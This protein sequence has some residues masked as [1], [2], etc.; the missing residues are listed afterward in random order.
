MP[1][2]TNLD[3]LSTTPSSNSPAGSESAALVDEYLRQTAA[4]LATLRNRIAGITEGTGVV[5]PMG[6]AGA[7]GPQGAQGIQGVAGPQGPAGTSVALKG[8]IATI[9]ALPAIGNT[10]GDLYVVLADGNG[11]VWSGSGWSNAGPIRGPAGATGPA[12]PQGPTGATGPQGATGPA[13]DPTLSAALAVSTDP[14]KGPGLINYSRSTTYAAGTVGEK[15]TR[16]WSPMDAPYNAKGDGTTDDTAALASFFTTLPNNAV[17]DLEGRSYAVYGSVSGIAA[18]TDALA[19]GSCLRLSSKSNITIRNGRIFAASPGTSGSLVNF[20][21]TLSIDGCTNIRLQ[22]VQLEAKGESYGNSDSSS[23]LSTTARRAYLA[24]N[25]G[26]A[27]VVI[28]SSG[29]HADDNCRFIRAGST[30]S[31]YASSSDNVWLVGAYSSPMS[32]GYAAFCADSWCGAIATSGFPAHRMHLIGCR[33]DSNGAT[34]GS[35]GCVLGEDID[36]TVNVEG[37][38]FKDAYANGSAKYLGYAFAAV[39]GTV[40]VN[41]AAVE[42]CASIGCTYN[43]AASTSTLEVSNTVGRKLR[44]AGHINDANPFGT[45][46]VKYTS[47]EFNVTGTSLWAGVAGLSSSSIIANMK[48]SSTINVDL[49][50]CTGAGPTYLAWNPNGCYGGLRIVGGRYEVFE[51]LA[52]SLGWGGSG[53][54]TKRGI[55][56]LSGATFVCTNTG[57]STAMIQQTNN[58]A[59]NSLLTYTY[60]DVDPSCIFES[61]TAARASEAITDSSGGARIERLNLPLNLRSCLSTTVRKGYPSTFKVVSLDGI[62]G[63]NYRLTVSFP[64][65]YAV[66]GFTVDDN[67]AARNI[68]SYQAGVSI[69][70]GEL[71][72]QINI[73]G[74]TNPFT[75]GAT[76]PIAGR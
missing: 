48:K 19:L 25:G 58:D 67:G 17:A 73:N 43:T 26:H 12:G 59:A 51:Q 32:L 6:P 56:M 42:N 72:G 54:G 18:P 4:H 66:E 8:S 24:Q 47:C 50:N 45:A 3:L 61:A 30:A 15:L 14:T 35:K 60:I 21:S 9:G 39:D 65:G 11:Y 70:S 28:R 13:G 57:S 31:F 69:A 22:N 75:V 29:F 33:S 49:I 37:G 20:P 71:R 53:A 23:G 34:Y 16:V 68:L 74:T 55:E 44:T 64:K 2:Q 5:G 76:Y 63:S 7:T 27:C 41:G 62:F 1:V 46:I 52:L 36:V 40:Y 38:V 10:A